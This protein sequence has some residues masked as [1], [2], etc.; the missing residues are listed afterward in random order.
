L[1]PQGASD[2]LFGNIFDRPLH[3]PWGSNLALKFMKY[4]DPALDHDLTSSTMPWALSPL[5]ASMPHFAHA[6]D[7]ALPFPPRDSL[8]DDTSQLHLAVVSEDSPC[9][10][11]RQRSSSDSSSSSTESYKRKTRTILRT[12]K[13]PDEDFN[14]ANAQQRRTYFSDISNTDK[15]IFGPQDLISV[16]FCY[17]FIEFTPT[18]SLRLPGGICFD[19]MR[20][21]DGQPVRFVCCD[22]PRAGDPKPWGEIFWCLVIEPY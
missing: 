9:P 5:L 4:I 1:N 18:L 7:R 20:Y 6:R 13:Q 14:F 21:W 16:D 12:K 17:G 11:P 8:C 15:V 3:L 2:V 10:S 22:R 19:L